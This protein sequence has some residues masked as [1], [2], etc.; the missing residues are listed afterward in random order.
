M[1]EL[2]LFVRRY[3]IKISYCERML[4]HSSKSEMLNRLS[5][6]M[7]VRS[8][9]L[10]TLCLFQIFRLLSFPSCSWHRQEEGFSRDEN[11]SIS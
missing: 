8:L 7:K 10:L 1:A 2:M 11:V 9:F 4:S 6:R 3:R 5:E